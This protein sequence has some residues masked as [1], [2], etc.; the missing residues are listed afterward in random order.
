MDATRPSTEA[1]RHA[2]P[3]RLGRAPA[4][5]SALLAAAGILLMAA[6]P[7]A[8]ATVDRSWRGTVGP[9]AANGVVTVVALTTGTGTVTLRLKA[10][11]RSAPVTVTIRAGTCAKPGAVASTLPATRSSATGAVSRTVAVGRTAVSRMKA[12]SALIAQVRSTGFSR[13]AVLRLVATPGPSPSPSSSG[14]V[15]VR[16]RDFAFSPAT[17]TA[18]AGKPIV[19]SFR[20]DDAGIRHGISV[21]TS[22][23]AAPIAASAVITGVARTTFTIPALSAGTYL[24]WCPVHPSMTGKL[25]VTGVAGAS[26]SPTASA[27]AGASPSSSPTGQPSPGASSSPTTSPTLPPTPEPTQSSGPSPSYSPY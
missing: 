5:A 2:G 14:E 3:S 4:A 17:I 1:G 22:V 12:A 7:A 8:S 18:A 9:S 19:V 11:P 16:G 6:A 25:V 21:G 24:F 23:S 26:A 15:E 27:G 10:L 20:N 13:C